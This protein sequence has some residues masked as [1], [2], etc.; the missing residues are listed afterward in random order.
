MSCPSEG[1]FKTQSKEYRESV[2]PSGAKTYGL[3]AGL[4]VTLESLVGINGYV[5][6]LDSFGQS[7]PYKVLDKEFGFTQN[8]SQK[9]III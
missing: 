5:H 7:A 6:G 3:T 1:L 2:L 4:P 9:N 8:I